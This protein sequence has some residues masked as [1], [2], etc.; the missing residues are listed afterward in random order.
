MFSDT[1]CFMA[2]FVFG[3]SFVFRHSLSLD[4]LSF[5]TLYIFRHYVIGHSMF[6]ETLCFRTPPIFNKNKIFTLSKFIKINNIYLCIVMREFNNT[7]S[8]LVD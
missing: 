4:T 6:S 5:R 7:Y 2:L 8:I 1:L 3:H